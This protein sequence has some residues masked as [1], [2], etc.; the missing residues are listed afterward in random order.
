LARFG[1]VTVVHVT[2]RPDVL[3]SRLAMRG[4]E[5][6]ATIQARLE[7]N[8]SETASCGG[9]ID[10]DNSGELAIAGESLLAVIRSFKA[11]GAGN[12]LIQQSPIRL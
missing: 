2:A 3:A 10:I 6:A 9:W 4:R 1:K 7:R 12:G 8:P 11:S 5:D